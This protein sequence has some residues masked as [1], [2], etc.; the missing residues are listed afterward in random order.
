MAEAPRAVE[1]SVPQLRTERSTP[2]TVRPSGS[3]NQALI[4]RL[5]R[6]RADGVWIG[7]ERA[8]VVAARARPG[9]SIVGGDVAPPLL[10][11]LANTSS[12]SRSCGLVML[13]RWRRGRPAPSNS[14][15]RPERTRLLV[16]EPDRG[17]VDGSAL[18]VL[19]T[20]SRIGFADV[21][22][23]NLPLV[24]AAAPVGTTQGVDDA[25]VQIAH[26]PGVGEALGQRSSVG[27]VRGESLGQ[28][29]GPSSASRPLIDAEPAVERRGAVAE[30]GSL[31]TLLAL[32]DR[33]LGR[34]RGALRDGVELEDREH[35]ERDE[36][37]Q[38]DTDHA[39]QEAVA[40]RLRGSRLRGRR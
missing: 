18:S 29:L 9:R 4:P 40:K 24:C 11:S 20:T 22:A 13:Y 1:T 15:K 25:I 17:D 8:V 16:L 28:R 7:P 39:E 27:G 32:K 35:G 19:P 3:E 23:A 30:V 5:A 26:V 34:V 12:P 33:C 37:Q 2:T 21:A 10:P 38:R 36:R 6:S 14:G 31:L